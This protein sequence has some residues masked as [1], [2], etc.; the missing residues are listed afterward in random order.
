MFSFTEFCNYLR[1]VKDL[2]ASNSNLNKN[3]IK[4]NLKLFLKFLSDLKKLFK[5]LFPNFIGVST[6]IF[7][8]LLID[9]IALEFV[10]YQVGLLSGKF[11]KVL[12]GRDVSGF[13]SLAIFAIALIIINSSMKSFN[14]FLA[15]L[16]QIVWRKQ[17][18]L[19]LHDLYFA[20]KNF[21]YVQNN[22][23]NDNNRIS[24]ISSLEF[25]S[26]NS[27]NNNYNN[28]SNNNSDLNILVGSN[29]NA[30]VPVTSIL[31]NNRINVAIKNNQSDANEN[32]LDNI[33]QR[34]TQDVN[35][36][37]ESISNIVGLI[38]ISPFIIGWYG[39]QVCFVYFFSYLDYEI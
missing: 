39:Y 18:T 37:C 26:S 30:T 8:L 13:T 25:D 1:G 28:N 7:V 24:P 33:D 14:D 35:S 3:S 29:T 32:F 17:I 31:R 6:F 2:P 9:L 19:K 23:L 38:L 11:F 10:I 36:L 22:V 12:T 34:I 21:Y 4:H 15:R 16:L 5:L 27:N 20:N